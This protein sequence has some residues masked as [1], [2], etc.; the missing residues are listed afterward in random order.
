M[1]IMH[2]SPIHDLL[3][4]RLTLDLG[5]TA[6]AVDRIEQTANLIKGETDDIGSVALS[7][8]T[9]SKGVTAVAA[10]TAV[11]RQNL[12]DARTEAAIA[13]Q[14]IQIQLADAQRLLL[15]RAD[16]SD[17][18]IAKTLGTPRVDVVTDMAALMKASADEVVTRVLAGQAPARIDLNDTSAPLVRLLIQAQ[19]IAIDETP[20]DVFP[21]SDKRFPGWLK[22]DGAIV[23]L[24]Q[25]AARH[26]VVLDAAPNDLRARFLRAFDRFASNTLSERSRRLADMHSLVAE[27]AAFLK[28]A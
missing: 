4:T 11:L 22:D 8:D 6:T 26:A 16:L 10:D 17:K 24:G 25:A 18:A 3:S 23:T 20:D 13:R 28:G 19:A 9:A 2:I 1:P 7:A 27:I 14:Q 15:D 5:P 21:K 12:A